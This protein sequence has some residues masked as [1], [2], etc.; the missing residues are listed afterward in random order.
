MR[1]FRLC[2]PL[3]EK[4][5]KH[6]IP[7][8]LTKEE[9]NLERRFPPAKCVG[10]TYSYG[11]VLPEGLL[12]RFIVETYVHGEPA[13]AWRTG[14]VLELMNCRALVRGDVQ[15]RKVSIRVAGV[16]KG[17]RQLLGIVREHFERI[18]RTYES[19]PVFEEVPI[20]GYPHAHV[21]Y[22]LL[23]K[24]ELDGRDKIAV[25]VGDQLV[26]CI[27]RDL[28]DGVDL[29][30]ASRRAAMATSRSSDELYLE[31]VKRAQSHT[32]FIS[33]SHK[34]ERFRDEL[35][36]AL[37]AFER[38]GQLRGWDD[39]QIVPGQKWE[40]EILGKLERADIVVFLLSNDFIRSGYCYLK[41]AKRALERHAAREC[42]VV[43]IVVRA[44]RFDKLPLGEIQAIVPR[45]R[46]I[47][48]HT[49][50]DRAWLEVTKQF[51]QIVEGL[52]KKDVAVPM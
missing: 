6:L 29:P 44:C 52:N 20:P 1:K 21:K 51:D 50:R 27:V 26:D 13:Q 47:S 28:L 14:V 34:D 32:F 12:P 8:L 42:V 43:P 49:N 11:S 36:G 22:E 18:H 33:Y 17:R 37:T 38:L 46:P 16:G 5:D 48:E 7:E 39:T 10:F 45:R 19:L 31:A 15:G 3:D 23:L 9:P 4:G 25:D 30:G 2:H 35:K 41:E 24:Y 40:P